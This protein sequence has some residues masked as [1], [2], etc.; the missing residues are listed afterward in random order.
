MD[1]VHEQNIKPPILL[2]ATLVTL[3]FDMTL[4]ERDI[5]VTD[6]VI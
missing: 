3:N 5:N 6:I 2:F 1:F 4:M